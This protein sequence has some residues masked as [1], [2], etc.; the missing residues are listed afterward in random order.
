MCDW[1]G[2][3]EGSWFGLGK[4]SGVGIVADGAFRGGEDA[5]HRIVGDRKGLDQT[6]IGTVRLVDV[7][8]VARARAADADRRPPGADEVETGAV[9]ALPARGGEVA[10][11]Y[12]HFDTSRLSVLA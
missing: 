6:P 1:N 3:G 9:L 5:V 11:V 2:H 7:D 8:G 12:L 10:R 4:T